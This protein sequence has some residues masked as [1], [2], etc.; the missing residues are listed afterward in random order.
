[1]KELNGAKFAIGISFLDDKAGL[2]RCLESLHA[3]VDLIIAVD[4][5]YANFEHPND[6]SVDGSREMLQQRYGHKLILLDAPNLSEVEKRNVYMRKLEQEGI[7]YAMFVDSDEY[8]LHG[9]QYTNWYKFFKHV[10][11]E[12]KASGPYMTLYN[13]AYMPGAHGL[14]RF[15]HW[16]GEWEYYKKHFIFR[17]ISTGNLYMRPIDLGEKEQ[18]RAVYYITLSGDYRYRHEPY[19]QARERY[20]KWLVDYENNLPIFNVVPDS[21]V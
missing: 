17:H 12:V 14:P 2:E 8:V 7:E 3:N 10:R 11:T 5:R 16:P 4:G 9:A 6:L 1:M 13:A 18:N 15:F 21:S 19:Q 20:Q